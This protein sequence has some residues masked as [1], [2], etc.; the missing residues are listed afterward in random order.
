MPLRKINLK[1]G[2][3]PLDGKTIH[4]YGFRQLQFSN[5]FFMSSYPSSQYKSIA[6]SDLN[7]YEMLK[8]HKFPW[9]KADL[10]LKCALLTAP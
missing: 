5:E 7:A 2:I 3:K 8:N 6:I 10:D 4:M 9:A 1:R